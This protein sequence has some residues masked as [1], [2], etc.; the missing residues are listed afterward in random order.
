MPVFCLYKTSQFL[1]AF[2]LPEKEK[3]LMCDTGLSPLSFWYV[4]ICCLVS[5]LQSNLNTDFL[6]FD[7]LISGEVLIC[8]CH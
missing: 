3:I 5:Q 2:L 8:F 6:L 4:A 1:T 7:A